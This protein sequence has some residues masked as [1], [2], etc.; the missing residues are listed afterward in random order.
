MINPLNNR[1][2][3]IDW[4]LAKYVDMDTELESNQ[5]GRSVRRTTRDAVL[6]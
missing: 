5:S 1:A 6:H 2:L 4:D 3:V